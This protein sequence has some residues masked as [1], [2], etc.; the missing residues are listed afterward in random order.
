VTDFSSKGLLPQ[1]TDV[2]HALGSSQ[3]LLLSKIQRVRVERSETEEMGRYFRSID[4][5]EPVPQL[6]GDVPTVVQTSGIPEP[7]SHGNEPH[8]ATPS[9]PV[10]TRL[11]DE[12]LAAPTREM[13]TTE[14]GPTADAGADQENRNYNFFDE[15]DDKLAGLDKNRAA[16]CADGWGLEG[17]PPEGT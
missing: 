2:L 6:H 1:L 14:S 4:G 11:P 13:M 17:S 7:L 15:L 16:G 9:A 12:G 10:F 8:V 3:A 5:V